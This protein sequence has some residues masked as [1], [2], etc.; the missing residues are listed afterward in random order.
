MLLSQLLNILAFI[1]GFLFFE[2]CQKILPF[3][4]YVLGVYIDETP[5][6]LI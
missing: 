3:R 4:A 5:L 2:F 6:V 1:F